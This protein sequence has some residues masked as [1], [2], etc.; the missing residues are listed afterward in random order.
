MQTK[1]SLLDVYLEKD[2]M[3]RENGIPGTWDEARSTE[4]SKRRRSGIYMLR[5]PDFFNKFP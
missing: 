5:R 3:V 1:Q 2:S 4:F